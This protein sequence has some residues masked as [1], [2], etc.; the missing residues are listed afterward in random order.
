MNYLE[1]HRDLL[2]RLT[3]TV[4]LHAT[5]ANA[6]DAFFADTGVV[7]RGLLTHEQVNSFD[8]REAFSPMRLVI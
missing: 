8:S 3:D 4:P 2:R 5:V 1:P 6:H 7:N